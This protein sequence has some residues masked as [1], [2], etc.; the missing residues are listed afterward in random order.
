[1]S[2]ED[3]VTFSKDACL[4]RLND[5]EV[6]DTI[7]FLRI[8]RIGDRKLRSNIQTESGKDDWN[9]IGGYVH[10]KIEDLLTKLTKKNSPIAEE[11]CDQFFMADGLDASMKQRIRLIAGKVQQEW[12]NKPFFTDD[13]GG[14]MEP[15]INEED[16]NR[17]KLR[18]MEDAE[19]I[20]SSPDPSKGVLE[21]LHNLIAG[22][23]NNK[24]LVFTL[25]ITGKVR[26]KKKKAVICALHEAGAGKTWTLKNIASLYNTHEASHLTKKAL[27]YMAEQLRGVVDENGNQ[28]PP[29]EVKPKEILY[30]Q[31]LGLMDQ[32]AGGTGNASIKGLSTDD[33]GLITT[34]TIRD[35]NGRFRTVTVRTDPITVLTSSTRTMAQ[36]DPQ[37]VRRYWVYSPDASYAQ[38]IRIKKFQVRNNI[39]EDDVMLNIREYTDLDYSRWVLKCVVDG[40]E[41]KYIVVPFHA[42]IY[43]IM[44]LQQIRVRGDFAKIKILLEM[45]GTLNFRNLPFKQ[46]DDKIVYFLTPEKALDILLIARQSLIF[47]ARDTEQRTFDFI[48]ILLQMGYEKPD[49]IGMNI[50]DLDAQQKIMKRM[51]KSRKSLLRYFKDLVEIGFAKAETT[52]TSTSYTLLMNPLEMYESL[53]AYKNLD[54]YDEIEKIYKNMIEEANLSFERRGYDIRYHVDY[55]Y[56][57][58]YAGLGVAAKLLNS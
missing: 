5:E 51:K 6:G 18:A 34:Y 21:H 2:E 4:G 24:M 7:Y 48:D 16:F 52:G 31:E 40:L 55:S 1:M 58:K 15:L 46:F 33:G 57:A 27:N 22:E 53:S 17:H 29:D 28:V 3:I 54:S 45:Y 26:N 37:F 20:L 10:T 32:E 42:S 50:I 35:D 19:K 39:Q 30:L 25:A 47:M 11:I 9:L 41:E 49:D 23:D 12:M 43:D 8:E 44:D 38:T 13:T 56:L 14:V 36:I